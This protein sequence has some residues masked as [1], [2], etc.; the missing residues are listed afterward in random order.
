MKIIKF[1][2]KNYKRLIIQVVSIVSALVIFCIP[3]FADTVV[4]TVPGTELY[5]TDLS[6]RSGVTKSSNGSVIQTFSISNHYYYDV[7]N[8]ARGRLAYT[9]MDY[10]RP[11]A[12]NNFLFA[13]VLL[14][15]PITI[16]A[17]R[18]TKITL[19]MTFLVLTQRT[20]TTNYLKVELW[21]GNNSN[22]TVVFEDKNEY[23]WGSRRTTQY[24][25]QTQYYNTCVI[26]VSNGSD[27]TL[28]FSYLRFAIR[29]SSSFRWEMDDGIGFTNDITFEDSGEAFKTVD[30][31]KLVA[32]GNMEKELLVS[33]EQGRQDAL[34][35]MDFSNGDTN[36]T[37]GM[38]AVTKIVNEF[39]D[40]PPIKSILNFSLSLG[41][42]AFLL[43]IGAI[44]LFKRKSN[45]NS[46][47]GS[48]T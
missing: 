20:I 41:M 35:I 42:A 30:N 45:N 22:G 23:Q 24:N 6:L 33:T 8:E 2:K 3:V 5:F 32:Y 31:S 15:E 37:N 26:E 34:E 28:E 36:I 47:K 39:V 4:Q 46:D 25:N 21:N 29:I 10:D 27:K 14:P 44:S 38:L 16:K 17:G 1:I 13:T 18:L 48:D 9:T 40:I 43:G 19:P 12:T 11:T 7:D